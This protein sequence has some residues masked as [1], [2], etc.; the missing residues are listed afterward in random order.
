MSELEVLC[1]TT[2]AFEAESLRARLQAVGIDV[3]LHGGSQ[4]SLFGGAQNIIEQQ[5]L[6]PA[7]QLAEAQAFL[8]STKVLDGTV[9]SGED[10]GNGVCALHEKQAVAICSR[11]GNFLCES[12]GSLG[13]PPLCEECVER[14]EEPVVRNRWAKTVAQAYVFSWVI[15]IAVLLVGSVSALLVWWWR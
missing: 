10:L 2:D 4:A 15:G 9:A 12:C 11:C 8:E 1:R 3:V 5:L 7:G 14:P 13:T 6:V